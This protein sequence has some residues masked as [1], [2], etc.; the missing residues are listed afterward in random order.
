MPARIPY[1]VCFPTLNLRTLLWTLWLFLPSVSILPP[2][3]ALSFGP[4]S[5]QLTPSAQLLGATTPGLKEFLVLFTY[6]LTYLFT[7]YFISVLVSRDILAA[8]LHLYALSGLTRNSASCGCFSFILFVLFCGFV[9]SLYILYS[10]V[11]AHACMH[12]HVYT[13]VHK[14]CG[15]K[16]TPVV[17]LHFS[18]PSCS[19][20]ALYT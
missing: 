8:R 16:W 20:Q 11:C 17:F 12:M 5:C 7:K 14:V 15:Q 18:A 1:G 13:R 19:R 6:S 3:L 2:E 4:V 9:W 10:C